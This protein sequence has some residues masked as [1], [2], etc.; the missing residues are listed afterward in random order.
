MLHTEGL[1]DPVYN[2][3][4]NVAKLEVV[5]RMIMAKIKKPDLRVENLTI[6][7]INRDSQ[8]QVRDVAVQVYLNYINN[9]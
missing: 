6:T 7:V 2:T 1:S 8:N 5:M 4:L 9:D 3:K